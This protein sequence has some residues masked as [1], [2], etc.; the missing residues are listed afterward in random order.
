MVYHK[1][2]VRKSINEVVVLIQA[3]KVEASGYGK[4]CYLRDYK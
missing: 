4:E 2:Q 1:Y 3:K